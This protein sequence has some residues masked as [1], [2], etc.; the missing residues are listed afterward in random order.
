MISLYKYRTLHAVL[1]L[2]LSSSLTLGCSSRPKI[3]LAERA[4]FSI[5]KPVESLPLAN[6][7]IDESTL[8]HLT[9]EQQADFLSYYY[10]K[11]DKGEEGHK[12]IYSYL[13]SRLSNFNYYSE[14]FKASES[15][16]IEE[17]NCMT[18]AILTTALAKL[19]N[20]DFTF[21]LMISEPI[22]DKQGKF[23]TTARHVNTRLFAPTLEIE[24]EQSEEKQDEDELPLGES[25]DS[26]LV[27]Y[28]PSGDALKGLYIDYDQFISLYFENA[29][30]EQLIKGNSELAY[31]YSYQAWQKKKVSI[32]AL[33]LL[34]VTSRKLNKLNQAEQNLF[35]HIR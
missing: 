25:R 10:A 22:Y 34:A 24:K 30:V 8:F 2:V 9:Q 27:D 20:I 32:S 12:V 26:I 29:A 4:N 6:L 7:P 1:L 19:V 31:F 21:R 16:K 3:H 15:L 35:T 14:T 5:E 33:N 18:L 11:L 23:I 17:G 13:V 28:F